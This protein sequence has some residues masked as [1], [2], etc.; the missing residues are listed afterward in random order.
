MTGLK[1]WSTKSKEESDQQ[2]PE[3]K[4]A[5]AAG[6]EWL[7]PGR[8]LSFGRHL[9]FSID[10]VS[11][12]MAAA[13]HRGASVVLLAV[14]K[15]YFPGKESDETATKEFLLQTIS[16]FVAEFGGR[17]PSVS[18][19]LD[20]PETA[21]RSVIMPDM[22]PA[23]LASALKFEAK[24]Q[25][26]FP[27]DECELDYRRVQKITD[28]EEKRVKIAILAATRRLIREKLEAFDSLN[29]EVTYL[30][31]TQDVIGQLLTSLPSHDPNSNYALIS[32]QRHR[33]EISY[34]HG[35]NLEFVHVS[36][37][38]SAF[39]ANRTDP[40]M[41]EYFA[42][43]LATEIQNSLDY[44]SGQY[45]AHFDNQIYV[46]GDLAY[47]DDLVTLLNDRFGLTFVRF[48]A[49][50]L[51]FV[52]GTAEAFVDELPASLPA[53]ASATSQAQLANL[54]PEKRRETLQLR[55]VNRLGAVALVVLAGLFIASWLGSM[56]TT[57]SAQANL[58]ELQQQEA[59]F[60]ASEMFTTYNHLK[61]TIAANQSFVNRI[62]ETPSYLGLNLKELTL[63]APKAVRLQSLDYRDEGTDRNYYISGLVLTKDVPP[64]LVLA[65]FVEN[66]ESSPFYEKVNI[67]R[68]V[69]K[70]GDA[71]FR[72]DFTLSMKGI[73]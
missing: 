46:Y 11:V 51:T 42:E 12:Q 6:V 69:K 48:P 50:Q 29:L 59:K 8:R 72:L 27:H 41:F 62:K 53:V 34:Y 14:G 63:L 9:A 47:S 73:I 49:E 26:P 10:E 40:T 67:D 35:C 56:A 36:S 2:K 38:G 65:E 57:R 66:L 16:S 43:S 45:S 18:I 54:L 20:G 60:R 21:L 5:P 58:T 22:R 39:L 1:L 4:A 3:T 7:P 13:A 44:Y 64:E 15:T 25:I 17:R 23:E 37:L 61:R 28:N 70:R 55:R 19:T 68:N 71:I 32:I 30:H 31:Q 52:K 24:R 33:S